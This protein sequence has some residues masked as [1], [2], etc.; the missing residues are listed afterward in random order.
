MRFFLFIWSPQGCENLHVELYSPSRYFPEALGRR[1]K[2]LLFLDK[3]RC[4]KRYTQRVVDM[5]EKPRSWDPELKT[6][7]RGVRE[8]A[9]SMH[10]TPKETVEE[11]T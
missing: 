9:G 7:L 8:S 1:G 4:G 2:S 5:T 3:L 10:L 6:A 11:V